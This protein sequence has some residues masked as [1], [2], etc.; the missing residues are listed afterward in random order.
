MGLTYSKLLLLKEVPQDEILE[1]AKQA[2]TLTVVELKEAV[3]Q[4]ADAQMSAS[5]RFRAWVPRRVAVLLEQAFLASLA[6]PVTPEEAQ[7]PQSCTL[8]GVFLVKLADHF[9]MAWGGDRMPP[10]TV[11]QKQRAKYH[12]CCFPGCS[13]RSAHGHHIEFR[14]QGG[15][16]D[17]W[18]RIPLC[19]YHHL[20]VVHEGF[21]T[22]TGIFPE[23]VEVRVGGVVWKDA[24]FGRTRA[25]RV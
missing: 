21:A 4:K 1:L 12:R 10:K 16:E 6:L 17:D 18:N 19:A 5:K 3:Q 9:L 2:E 13:R 15:S 23:A 8:D 20:V 7:T 24:Q 25:E 11:S 22:I 14:S